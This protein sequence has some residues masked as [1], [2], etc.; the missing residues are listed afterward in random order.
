MARAEAARA[1]RGVARQKGGRRP[2]CPAGPAVTLAEFCHAGTSGISRKAVMAIYQRIRHPR[3]ASR[4]ADSLVKV[5]DL[6][7]RRSAVGSRHRRS[8]L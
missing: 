5:A 1:K 3:I 7:P 8:A 2:G 6:L 4:R